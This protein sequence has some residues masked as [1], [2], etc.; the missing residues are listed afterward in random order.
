VTPIKGE[1]LPVTGLGRVLRH[2]LERLDGLDESATPARHQ[3]LQR[4]GGERLLDGQYALANIMFYPAKGMMWG[5]ELQ[6]GNRKNFID[7]FSSEDFRV[8][9]S[10]KYNFSHQL[11]GGKVR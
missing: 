8:Q 7:H 9:V 5:P 4:A 11:I 2:Q 1:S 6:W 3:Q 10:F